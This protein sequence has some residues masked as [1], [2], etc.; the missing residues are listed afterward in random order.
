MSTASKSDPAAV[1]LRRLVTISRLRNETASRIR[2]SSLALKRGAARWARAPRADG[3]QV[4]DHHRGGGH[5][6]RIAVQ[7]QALDALQRKLLFQDLAAGL[8]LEFR[9]VEHG[10]QDAGKLGEALAEK[11][12]FVFVPPGND[13][14][15]GEL[16]V[17]LVEQRLVIGGGERLHFEIGD[18]EVHGGQGQGVAVA[19]DAGDKI[20]QAAV[21]R[22]HFQGGRRRQDVGDLPAHEPL[23]QGR[24]LHLLADGDLEALAQQLGGIIFPGVVGNAAQRHRVLLVLVARGQDHFQDGGGDP[25][26]VEEHLVEIAEAEKKNGVGIAFFDLA[27]LAQHGGGGEVFHGRI[28]PQ[29]PA[30]TLPSAAWA[31]GFCARSAANS[32]RRG[33]RCFRPTAGSVFSWPG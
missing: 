15:L 6:G 29:A 4:L 3:A 30:R 14:L 22:F 16:A 19:A 25:G 20:V 9:V 32:R 17:K 31:E 13:D 27:V 2:Y 26:V 21:Q 10:D 18:P 23:G 33:P 11:P 7:A 12:E 5:G 1:P 28:I 8:R 24:V